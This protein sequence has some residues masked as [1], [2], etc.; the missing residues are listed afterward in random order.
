MKKPAAAVVMLG[1][2]V[3]VGL[4]GY[5]FATYPQGPRGTPPTGY[6]P[7][8]DDALA[9][10]YLPVFD[11]PEA[12]GSIDAI[13][14]RAAE[15][16]SGVLHLAY[17]PV[18]ARERNDTKAFLPFLSR[19]L[20][21]GGL[22]LQRAMYGKGDVESVGFSVDPGTGKIL[23]VE[24]ETAAGY[25]PTDFSVTHEKVLVQ[26]PF[27]LPLSFRVVSWNHLFALDESTPPGNSP[28]QGTDKPSLSYFSPDLW[29]D[30]AMWKNPE[31]FLRKDRAHFI[32]ERAASP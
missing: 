4:I 3:V 30:Y 20:Y 9:Q 31:T 16:E 5:F 23:D 25:S 12:F 7:I 29:N 13:Y 18:W 32:W 21:T 27:S 22:S 26:G 1:G 8:R 14:Y 2:I 15:D 24:Y 10:R 19:W 11:C 28:Q 6:T 17:H